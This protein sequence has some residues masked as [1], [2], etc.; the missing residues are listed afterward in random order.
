MILID[1]TCASCPAH[2]RLL[3]KTKVDDAGAPTSEVDLADLI[4][5]MTDFGWSFRG[6]LCRDC[7]K[8]MRTTIN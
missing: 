6:P 8:K 5:Q 1:A 3:C 2:L 7:A 4:L